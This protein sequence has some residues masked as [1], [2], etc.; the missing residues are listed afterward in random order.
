MVLCRRILWQRQTGLT[1]MMFEFLNPAL[2]YN[3]AKDG[4]RLMSGR[5]R[6]L[7]PEQKIELRQKWK[8]LFEE[9]VIKNWREKLRSDVI[10]RDVRRLD[11][12]PETDEKSR[13]ISP[14]FRVG[15]IDLYHRGIVVAFRWNRLIQGGD[16]T[17][18][19]KDFE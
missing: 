7:T 13:G 2:L 1:L 19:E 10:I 14:W 15:L 8:P 6:K 12:Y 9:E 17:W 16:G 18:R 5:G 11:N 3:L 4:L